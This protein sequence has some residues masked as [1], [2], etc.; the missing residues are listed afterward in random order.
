MRPRRLRALA[1]LR[2]R[3]VEFAGD[4]VRDG[5]SATAAE[6][7]EIGAVDAEAATLADALVADGRVVTV[8]GERE[9]T[10][11]TADAGCRSL[12]D[13]LPAAGACSSWPD[14]TIAFLLLTLGTL[15][16]IFELANPGV[17]IGGTTG[18][19]ALLLALFSLSMLPV[20]VVGGLLLILAA[21]ML[22]AEAL[23]PGFGG[24]AA[25]GAVVLLFSAVFL[26]D[27]AEGV[28][29]DLKA[30]IPLALVILAAALLMGRVARRTRHEPSLHTGMDVFTGERCRYD[31]QTTSTTSYTEGA[32][33]SLRSTEHPHGRHGRPCRRCRWARAARGP[34]AHGRGSISDC[35]R[36]EGRRLRLERRQLP[37]L[38][39]P[40]RVANREGP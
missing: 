20:N 7:V 35:G 33:W 37:S 13:E 29:V 10:V 19:T 31:E 9:V 30:A 17:G 14:P 2:G 1:Q 36:S 26:F 18:A 32:W 8:P 40:S 24:F 39:L 6:A 27:D 28:S 5:R 22:I 34:A 38:E 16:L 12:R 15:G 25:G 11:T 4:T 21:A 3:N 23:A